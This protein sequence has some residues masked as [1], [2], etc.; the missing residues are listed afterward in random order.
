MTAEDAKEILDKV[1]A[2][3]GRAI[4]AAE[5]ADRP[6]RQGCPA[7]LRGQPPEGVLRVRARLLPAEPAADRRRRGHHDQGIDRALADPG[8]DLLLREGSSGPP[9]IKVNNQRAG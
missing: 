7:P 3:Y 4:E 2:M 6:E 5:R 1:A 9:R 8:R